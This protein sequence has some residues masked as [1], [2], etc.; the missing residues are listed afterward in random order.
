MRWTKRSHSFPHLRGPICFL[1]SWPLAQWRTLAI[2]PRSHLI[3]NITWVSRLLGKNSGFL[4]PDGGRPAAV[5]KSGSTQLNSCQFCLLL[6][7]LHSGEHW[8]LGLRS[9]FLETLQ[10][11]WVIQVRSSGKLT[12][13]GKVDQW[14]KGDE[15]E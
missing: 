14:G 12:G 6:M 7:V 4:A 11:R 10:M 15:S 13:E 9:V 8:E 1:V 5:S 2:T 3:P